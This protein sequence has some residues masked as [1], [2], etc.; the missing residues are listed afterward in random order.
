MGANLVA[1]GATFRVWAPNASAVHVRGDF[2]NFEIRDDAA[3]ICDGNG[4]WRGFIPGVQDQ[5]RYKFWID[6]QA[7]P[8]YKRDP[9][10]RELTNDSS[11]CIVRKPDFPWHETGFVT[12]QFSDF[13]IYQLHVGAFYAPHWPPHAGTFLDV[14]D[15]IP[16]LADLGVSVLQLM[17]IQEFPGDFSLGYNGTDYFSPEMAFGVSEDRLGPYVARANELLEAKGLS[18]FAE[19]YLTGGMN[20]LK[21]LIDLCHCYGLAVILDLVFNH[22][23]GG[24]GTESLWFFD[25]QNGS[26]D[27]P[28]QY[29]NSLFFSD[30]GWAGGN[31]FN[32]QNDGVRQF[33]INN[34]LFFLDEY[35]VDGFRYDEVSVIDSNG[36][37]RGWD[38]CQALTGT[39]RTHKPGGLQ[40]AEYWPVNPW[41]VKETSSGG[42]GFHT[43]MTDGLRI[44]LRD[45][46]QAA[47]FPGDDALPMTALASQLAPSGFPN[48]WCGV[49]GIENHD[50]VMQPKDSNDHNRMDRIPR[51]ADPSNPHSWWARSRSRVATGLVVTSPGIP[52]L[53]MGAG[54]SRGQA[55]V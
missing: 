23:G 38:F 34:A 12:P 51:L 47:S 52:M 3:L 28:P 37:G 48:F 40:H 32:F 53:F 2:N 35:R 11:N 5:Q 31:V 13:L 22:A 42:A 26:E 7:G 17:P 15:K 20:Q 10:A 36:N 21:A 55:M 16:Y 18:P 14:M 4:H 8:G 30:K 50:L 6:G 39:L 49:Q 19:E 29:W 24:F 44:A 1:D 27:T 33:L 45:V 54:I 41:V 9:Y 43:T 25:R 46:L